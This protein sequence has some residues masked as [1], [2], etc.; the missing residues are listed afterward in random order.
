M[1]NNIFSWGSSSGRTLELDVEVQT[2]LLQFILISPENFT[3]DRVEGRQ[4]AAALLRHRVV[5][6]AQVQSGNIKI[7]LKS[8]DVNLGE[9]TYFKDDLENYFFTNKGR[10]QSRKK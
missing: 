2:L 6:G 1:I 5:G 10:S 7:S 3:E 8:K 4:Q 9:Q